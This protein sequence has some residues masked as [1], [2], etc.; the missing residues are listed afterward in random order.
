M[1]ALT[2][3]GCVLGDSPE[4]YCD[5]TKP[6]IV[7]LM[8]H[9]ALFDTVVLRTGDAVLSRS[10]A[11]YSPEL[12]VGETVERLVKSAKAVVGAQEAAMFLVDRYMTA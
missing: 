10:L 9:M 3:V 1:S 2:D 8:H 4:K 5:L 11:A 7:A 12:H 6:A